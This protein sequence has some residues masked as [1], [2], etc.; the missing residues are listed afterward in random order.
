MKHVSHLIKKEIAFAALKGNRPLLDIAREYDVMLW[1]VIEWALLVRQTGGQIFLDEGGEVRTS[2]GATESRH[3]PR[4][5][6][7]HV[8]KTGGTTLDSH[9]ADCYPAKLVCPARFHPELE[10]LALEKDLSGY[11][12]LSGHFYYS[13]ILKYSGFGKET[14]YVTMLRDP[15]KRQI[16]WYLHWMRETVR[17][18]QH[19]SPLSH[20][21]N[22][23]CLYLSPLD[24]RR[25]QPSMRE[26]LAAAKEALESFFFVGIQE[27]FAESAGMLFQSLGMKRPSTIRVRNTAQ[28][29]A[30]ELSRELL[31]EIVERNWADIELYEYAK[32]LFEARLQQ[33]KEPESAVL[34]V[35]EPLPREIHYRAEDILR[36][37]NWHEREGL[38]Q[39]H[40]WRWSG[41]DVESTLEFSMQIDEAVEYRAS[42]QVLNAM[43]TRILKSFRMFV[44]DIPL[45]PVERRDEE[46]RLFLDGFVVGK[47]VLREQP[48]LCVRFVVSETK[49]PREI[50]PRVDDDRPCG[51]AF[52]EF[53][54]VEI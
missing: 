53:H 4:T 32:S 9:L 37:D 16:S 38:D 47:S 52:T 2:G 17:T 21:W 26:H 51:F 40:P 12:L 1:Q 24:T 49:M 18:Y 30:V 45:E 15:V 28:K 43:N 6:F 31:D 3:V 54:F 39:A 5:V 8:P 42:I 48:N 41:P 25:T 50:N 36:G 33:Q 10:N 29:H 13:W 23:Q 34:E 20:G 7:I 27:R 14:R 35:A 46:N 44:N 22:E 11:G 19:V